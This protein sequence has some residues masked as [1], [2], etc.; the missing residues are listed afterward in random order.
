METLIIFDRGLDKIT[1]LL[2][3]LLYQGM[4]DYEGIDGCLF[5]FNKKLYAFTS[6][7]EVGDE[8][9]GDQIFEMIKSL[10][11]KDAK[12]KMREQLKEIDKFREDFKEVIVV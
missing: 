2:S 7:K 11:I 5:E 6:V 3:Q 4:L 10:N 9:M 8:F 1:P 12:A